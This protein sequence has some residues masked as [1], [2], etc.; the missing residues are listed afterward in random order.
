MLPSTHLKSQA[1]YAFCIPANQNVQML[2]AIYDGLDPHTAP[3][4]IV[5]V[6]N[7]DRYAREVYVP[8]AGHAEPGGQVYAVNLVGAR[9]VMGRNGF[10]AARLQI[11]EAP[12]SDD[13]RDALRIFF[14]AQNAF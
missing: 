5:F 14:S 9:Y 4:G 13:A 12:I 2:G 7:E 10:E 3:L 6:V 8:R 11:G 1:D